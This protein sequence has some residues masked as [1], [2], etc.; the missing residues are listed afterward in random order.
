[1]IS[2]AWQSVGYPR[3]AACRAE[4]DRSG[5]LRH[6][7]TG[8]T[9]ST[10]GSFVWT[11]IVLEGWPWISA[12]LYHNRYT[13]IGPLVYYWGANVMLG[14]IAQALNVGVLAVG[15]FKAL[16]LLD[17]AGA[18]IT[19]LSI[20]ALLAHFDY[21]SAVLATILGQTTQILLM[22]VVLKRRLRQPLAL[23]T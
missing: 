5:F 15:E 14:S 21:S 17:L 22:A 8:A 19:S 7:L 6:M 11:A 4:D 20:F 23:A 3:M 9:V 16:A 1:M 10:A 2:A 12:V 13:E 18:V